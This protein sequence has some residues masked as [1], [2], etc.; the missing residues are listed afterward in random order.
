MSKPLKQSD[1][2][3]QLEALPPNMVGEIIDG[4]LLAMPRP[5]A[6]HAVSAASLGIEIGGPYQRGRGG[7]GGW[8]FMN[9][10]ELHFGIQ[11]TVPD[12]AGWRRERMQSIPEG[13]AITIPPNWVCEVL[14]PSTEKYDRGAKRRIYLSAGVEY[15]WLLNPISRVLET[16]IASDDEWK[17]G[18]TF[19]SG[20]TVSAVPFDAISFPIDY[21]WG[22]P[23][24]EAES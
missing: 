9:E 16:F 8:I 1:L 17:I 3:A 24:A 10:P 14:S 13:V 12:I 15:L 11:V 4:E 5:A 6:R 2:Y 23:V 19:A 22:D 21:L 7:P 18:P 20:D